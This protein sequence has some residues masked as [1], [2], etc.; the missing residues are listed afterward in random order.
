MATRL[1]APR[2]PP[3]PWLTASTGA[4]RPP[5]WATAAPLTTTRTTTR[6][7][8]RTTRPPR[9]PAL[10][11]CCKRST[12]AL[13]G[14]PPPLLPSSCPPAASGGTCASGCGSRRS[15]PSAAKVSRGCALP[16]TAW[17]GAGRA[18]GCCASARPLR[19]GASRA[20]WELRARKDTVREQIRGPLDPR[21]FSDLQSLGR[22]I[23]S[24]TTPCSGVLFSI[25][26][27]SQ[28]RDIF[29]KL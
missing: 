21:G 29:G 13:L 16:D 17:E 14:P 7:T 4:P 25:A 11:G 12:P 18:T 2:P 19:T 22:N 28:P 26:P 20:V 15:S 8:T 3:T 24:L 10:L 6:I 27:H 9:L 23:M 1:E 5:P